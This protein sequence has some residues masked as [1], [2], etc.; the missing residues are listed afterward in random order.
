MLH[1]FNSSPIFAIWVRIH[2]YKRSLHKK[3]PQRENN[4]VLMLR[5]LQETINLIRLFVTEPPKKHLLFNRVTRMI[6]RIPLTLY[7]CFQMHR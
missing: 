7:S 2:L 3:F 6:I 1:I 4:L 5:S